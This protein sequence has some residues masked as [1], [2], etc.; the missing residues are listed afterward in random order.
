MECRDLVLFVFMLF[1]DKW[2][3]IIFYHNSFWSLF[4]VLFCFYVFFFDRGGLIVF[5]T[6]QSTN[7]PHSPQSD[8]TYPTFGWVQVKITMRLRYRFLIPMVQH[9]YHSGT[10]M[11]RLPSNET[12]C[13]TRDVYEISL[14][15]MINLQLW[16]LCCLSSLSISRIQQQKQPSKW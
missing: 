5:I 2:E 15:K 13:K 11:T 9:G 4:L 10:Q 1:F 16:K 3:L 7:H 12:M 6:T 14:F 8:T